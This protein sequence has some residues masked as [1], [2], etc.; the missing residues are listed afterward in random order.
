MDILKNM[1]ITWNPAKNEILKEQR[2][3]DFNDV[4]IAIMENRVLDVVTHMNKDKYPNQR[5]MI[6]AIDNYIYVVPFVTD[7]DKTIFLKTIYPG[8]G[9]RCIILIKRRDQTMKK[10]KFDYIDSEEKEVMESFD[11]G[12]FVSV[13]DKDKVIRELKASAK[14]TI[15]KTRLVSIRLSEKDLVKIKAKSIETGIPYQTLIGSV[16][17]Q[18]A[19]D[20]IKIVL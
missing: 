12:E 10:N 3:V 11:K 2:G 6:I 19:E 17:H 15:A 16:L 20:K 5:M 13:K 7:G 18:F 14:N 8:V 9:Q 1:I 4:L